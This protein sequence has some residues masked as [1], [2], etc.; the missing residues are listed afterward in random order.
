M[1]SAKL[2][3][4][5]LTDK[6]NVTKAN[7][8]ETSGKFQILDPQTFIWRSYSWFWNISSERAVGNFFRNSSNSSEK[9]GCTKTA[10]QIA[11]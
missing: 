8:K 10:N 2:T 11:K 1:D 5:R 7:L 9:S 4:E 3:I 6:G